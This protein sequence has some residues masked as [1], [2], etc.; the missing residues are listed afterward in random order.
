M[1]HFLTLSGTAPH[2]EAR[3]RRL[4]EQVQGVESRINSISARY[5]YYVSVESLLDA[6]STQ[7]LCDLLDAAAT[8]PEE[9]QGDAV[10]VVP[11]IG[12]V[13]PWS[14]KATDIAH[15][16]GL[17]AVVRIERGIEY[18]LQRRG[19]FLA[20]R[21]GSPEALDDGRWRALAAV[22]HDRMTESALPQTPSAE[23]VFTRLPGQ[24]M[25]AIPVSTAGRT[26][27]IE[28][29]RALGLALSEDEIDY[30]LEAF[31]QAGR[32]PTDVELMMF[33]QAN[34]EHCRH[35]IFNASWTV[36]GQAVEGSLFDMIRSTHHANPSGTVVAYADNAAIL[37]GGEVDRFR[38]TEPGDA[39]GPYHAERLLTHSLLKVETHNHPTAIAPF[40][41]A[42]TGAGGEIRDEGA[43]GRGGRPR[44]GLTG[45]TVSNLQ[46]PGFE[47]PWETAQDVL[48]PR[49]AR[50]PGAAGI[51]R[52][53]RIASALS[54]MIEGPLGG[55]AFNNEFGRPNLL[56][57]FRTYEQNIGGQFRGYHKPIM[58][59][60]GVGHV[61]GRHAEKLGLDPGAL[62]IQ[63]GGPGL[64]IGVGGGAASSMNTGSNAAELDFG[65]V[66]RGNPEMQRRAQEVLDRCWSLGEA[67]PIRSIHDV[68][69]GGLSNAF[70]EL[71]HGAGRSAR[72][73]LTRVP[74]EETGM[75]PAEIW[76]NESQE[77]YVLAIAPDAFERF[78][79]LCQRERCPYAIVGEVTDDGRLVVLAREGSAAVD[80]DIEVLLGKPPRMH[81]VAEHEAPVRAALDLIGLELD[82]IAGQVLRLPAVASKGF[83]ITI[84]D[85]SVGGITTR[86]QMVGPW[87]VPVSNYALGLMDFA[88]YRAEA[89]SMGE[90]SPIAVL[91]PAAASRMAIGEA[92]TN[93]VGALP[94][95]LSALKLSA[96]WMAACGPA[97]E[98]AALRDA[99]EAAADFCR[100]AGLSI[101]V[102]KDSLSMRTVW[103]PPGGDA[104]IEVSAPVSLVVTAWAPVNDA[105]A[106]L[107][108]QL[109]ADPATTLILIDLGEGRMRMGGSALAQVTQQLGEEPPDMRDPESLRAL[110]EVLHRL[111]TEGRLLACH[112]RSDGGLFVTLCEMAFA[113]HCGLSI[114]LDLLTIDPHAADWGDF[115]I[116]PEQVAVQ[117]NELTLRALFNEELGVVIQVRSDDR[118]AVM[119]CLREAGLS[120]HAHVIGK[121]ASDDQVSFYRDGRRVWGARRTD[122][123]QKWSETGFRI[124]A[125]RDDPE[126]AQEAFDDCARA[127]D[128]G[129]RID[130]TFDPSVDVAAPFIAQGARPRLAVLREQG[131]NSHVEMAAAFDRA[132][133]DAF[134]V[135]MTDLLSGR[136]D[137]AD[138]NALAACGGFSYGDVLGA[139][140]GWARSILFNEHLMAMFAAF[141]AR[142][143]TLALGVCNGCQMMSQ[144]K[145]I[146]PGAAHWPRFLRNRSE[147]YEARLSMVEVLD[148]PS[149]WLRGMTGSR[150]P[151]AVAHGE[152]R[153]AFDAG[154]SASAA[155]ACL[156]FVDGQNQPAQRYPANPNGSEGGL[157]AFC[158]DDG[159]AMIM[160]PHPE[161]VFRSIQLSWRDPSLGEDS[162]WMRVFR[163]ARIAL[164]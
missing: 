51:G 79:A 121:P 137:L 19:R 140:T 45:F 104:P 70:P 32:D 136:A 75:S 88:G 52:P 112:D 156:R 76:C 28:A 162:P 48:V 161:R 109:K 132:G 142:P 17:V 108:P 54:I 118:D 106:A 44:F 96:N 80:M 110:V 30:L 149:L 129:L 128:P 91:N 143:D 8:P 145:S 144:L 60:G 82:E 157:T 37:E 36:D 115:K 130:L 164:G 158:S 116:R 56:G 141:F 10:F 61:D 123:Q 49:S 154:A 113:G 5:V 138:F 18:R 125:L 20:G 57:Y 40:A 99:V 68:G 90:R 35:K 42:A 92:V 73:D 33:A 63:L 25:R 111:G 148:S 107:T 114:N 64:R 69:A 86:D 151:I 6:P 122:L 65:S 78:S 43:T 139:G 74:L 38:V 147:Q 103:T 72:F 16:C 87:Q 31:G 71:V 134:D 9:P 102:G 152:G 7:R 85:R 135:H 94:S 22:L 62:L 14:S 55:A 29:D 119:G 2:S 159:R 124:A 12:T 131:V 133:F 100:R 126:C 84:G 77:R 105:R 93:M 47:Q 81:R 66:Q 50:T 155:R 146:V 15:N 120:R 13:S 83:L 160:M 53:E 41:G 27:L 39:P 34:S 127:D 58:I 59:A 21:F 23:T 67:N 11:R 46:I 153:V 26:A 4:L 3:M 89:L 1:P 101:P 150:M 98:D 117:R 24:P 97:A 163:N 95:R